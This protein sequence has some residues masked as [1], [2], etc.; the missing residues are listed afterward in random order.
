[1]TPPP[2]VTRRS[3]GVAELVP[4]YEVCVAGLFRGLWRGSIF[5]KTQ[6]VQRLSKICSGCSGVTGVSG[7]SRCPHMHHSP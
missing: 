6:H 3:L 7:T 2:V 4:G 1:M 5:K